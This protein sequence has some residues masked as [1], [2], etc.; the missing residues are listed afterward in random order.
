MYIETQQVNS[1]SLKDRSSILRVI[2]VIDEEHNSSDPTD[3]SKF[4][5]ESM[6]IRIDE[7]PETF[8]I[9]EFNQK[10]THFLQ[11][12][13]KNNAQISI[14][15]HCGIGYEH[16]SRRKQKIKDLSEYIE[17]PNLD[18]YTLE[19]ARY[20]K[21]VAINE[22]IK[23]AHSI[24]L[25]HSNKEIFSERCE[26]SMRVL[27]GNEA[28]YSGRCEASSPELVKLLEQSMVELA[29]TLESQQTSG[30]MVSEASR[31]DLSL[32]RTSLFEESSGDRS[33]QAVEPCSKP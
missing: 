15:F 19:A 17:Q 21:Q 23:F 8:N 32:S 25:I 9:E 20:G 18:K 11:Q 26:H 12:I 6:S 33:G 2:G 16:I 30:I 1:N 3:R 4:V 28:I 31:E 13:K 29:K 7:L 24:Q 5:S 27:Y 14:I 10:A 22:P